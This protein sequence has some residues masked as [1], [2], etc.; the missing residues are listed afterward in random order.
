MIAVIEKITFDAASVTLTAAGT[1][2]TAWSSLR[3]R[4]R[5]FGRSISM[6]GTGIP[7]KSL[8]F[9]VDGSSVAPPWPLALAFALLPERPAPAPSLVQ[10]ST[11]TRSSTSKSTRFLRSPN[12]ERITSLR[13]LLPRA[14]MLSARNAAMSTSI[15]TADSAWDSNASSSSAPEISR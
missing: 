9:R 4:S 1:N 13:G 8:R 12:S 6:S 3:I 7:R 14:K 15:F 11:S 2:T 5:V 10:D